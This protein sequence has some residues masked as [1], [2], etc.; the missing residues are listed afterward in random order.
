[1]RHAAGCVALVVLAGLATA[2]AAEAAEANRTDVL[3][4]ALRAFAWARVHAAHKSG[5]CGWPRSTYMIGLWEY[6]A[7]TLEAGAPDSYAKGDLVEWG[8]YLDYRLCDR[9]STSWTG[10]CP[11]ANFTSCAANQLP[12]ATYIELFRAGLDLPAPHSQRTLQATVAEFDAEI[13]LGSAGHGSWPIVDLT[14][15]AMAGGVAGWRIYVVRFVTLILVGQHGSGVPSSQRRRNSSAPRA[16]SA[17]E[18]R[19]ADG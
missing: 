1:M 16:G 13:A 15:M 12:G 2:E 9:N 10:P 3:D 11:T 17:L 18:A 7:A 6:Y 5:S 8:R 4:S 19:R 14:F